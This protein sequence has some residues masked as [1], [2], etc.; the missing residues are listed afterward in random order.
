MSPRN[1][2]ECSVVRNGIAGQAVADD[3]LLLDLSP[4]RDVA[5]DPQRRLA[6]VGPGVTWA[7]LDR[8]TCAHGL[9]TTGADV[10]SVGVIGTALVGGC[11]WLHRRDGL[12]CDRVRRMQVVTADAQVREVSA[13]GEPDL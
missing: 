3:A 6:R 13:D 8:A 9:A 7:E 12:T 10:S 5:V 1:T 11:G 4:M 2:N